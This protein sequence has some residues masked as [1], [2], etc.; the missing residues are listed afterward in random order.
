MFQRDRARSE[1]DGDEEYEDIRAQLV[2]G[3]DA[4]LLEM[5][6]DAMDTIRMMVVVTLIMEITRR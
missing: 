5:C 6:E 2:E 1:D 4:T 3:F